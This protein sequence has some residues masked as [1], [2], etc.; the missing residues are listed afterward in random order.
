MLH[1]YPCYSFSQIDVVLASPNH[2]RCL[3]N[4]VR[5]PRSIWH[6]NF[7]AMSWKLSPK[8]QNGAIKG[9]TF[10][11]SLPPEVTVQC[12]LLIIVGKECF[13]L[14]ILVFFWRMG[15]KSAYCCL[16]FLNE[17]VQC[18]N[19]SLNFTDLLMSYLPPSVCRLLI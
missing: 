3:L 9:L 14:F 18:Q 10:C 8:H 15:Y 5:Q 19:I 12:Y 2:S 1:Q 4:S 6:L 11:V 16:Q 7:Q 17:D 13:Y